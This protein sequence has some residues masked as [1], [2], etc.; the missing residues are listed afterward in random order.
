VAGFLDRTTLIGDDRELLFR[1][2]DAGCT[3]LHL[4]QIT[5]AHGESMN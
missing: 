3:A 1:A 5:A 4:H 2:S